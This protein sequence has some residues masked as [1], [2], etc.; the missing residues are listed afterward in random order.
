MSGD[1]KHWVGRVEASSA[2]GDEAET[3]ATMGGLDRVNDRVLP[4]G[5]QTANYQRNPVIQYGHA[6]TRADSVPIAMTTALGRTRDGWRIRWKWNTDEKYELAQRVRRAWD[7]GFLRTLSIGSK[8]L[9]WEPNASGGITYTSWEWLE[10]SVVPIPANAEATRELMALG[11]W[12][13]A[14]EPLE[15]LDLSP[16]RLAVLFVT[17]IRQNVPTV[18]DQFV[19]RHLAHR[20]GLEG[21][22]IVLELVGPVRHV[23]RSHAGNVV[24]RDPIVL[25]LRDEEESR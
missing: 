21:D 13:A 14:D 20:G 9:R 10:T 7:N 22:R 17:A 1:V 12:S 16:E 24:G 15:L 2:R 11:L 18:V 4:E 25:T 3:T 23:L 5:A 19:Q 8:P 6:V